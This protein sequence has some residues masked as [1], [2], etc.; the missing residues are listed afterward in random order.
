MMKLHTKLPLQIGQGRADRRL[1][2]GQHLGSLGCRAAFQH[3]SKDG[4]LAQGDMH[5]H[6]PGGQAPSLTTYID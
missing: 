5:S 2:E 4:Q 6:D 1:G 3:F